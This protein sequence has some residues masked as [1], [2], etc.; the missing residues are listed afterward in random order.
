MDERM[1]AEVLGM[2]GVG[3]EPNSALISAFRQLERLQS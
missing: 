3:M 2:C 1:C